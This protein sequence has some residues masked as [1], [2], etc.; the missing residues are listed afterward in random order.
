[1]DLLEREACQVQVL[2]GSNDVDLFAV[3]YSFANE[4]HILQ[5]K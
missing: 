3:V 4:W 5:A 2:L 1:M